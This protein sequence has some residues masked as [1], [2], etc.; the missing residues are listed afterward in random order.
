MC[1]QVGQDEMVLY[2][3]REL[4]ASKELD[5][6][7]TVKQDVLLSMALAKY[8]LARDL[9]GA[10]NAQVRRGCAD[11][12]ARSAT[13]AATRHATRTSSTHPHSPLGARARALA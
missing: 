7:D 1:T 8:N 4:L 2:L 9:I 12:L 11:R 10:P 5:S 13:A 6:Y 3:G